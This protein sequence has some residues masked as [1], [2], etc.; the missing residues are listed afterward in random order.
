MDD[1]H[2]VKSPSIKTGSS[3]LHGFFKALRGKNIN[4]KF[5][6]PREAGIESKLINKIERLNFKDQMDLFYTAYSK[7]SS[8]RHMTTL[9][10]HVAIA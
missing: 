5:S 1:A 3:G 10:G 6:E 2:L 9:A 4:E 8:K 7:V